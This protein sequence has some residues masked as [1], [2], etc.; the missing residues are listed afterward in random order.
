MFI[1]F[2]Y[3][4]LDDRLVDATKLAYTLLKVRNFYVLF[5]VLYAFRSGKN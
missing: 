5:I 1:S 4:W 3:E 2:F